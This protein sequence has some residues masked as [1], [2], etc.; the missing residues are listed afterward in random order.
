MSLNLVRS[1]AHNLLRRPGCITLR[2]NIPAMQVENARPNLTNYDHPDG[3]VDW[4]DRLDLPWY[5]RIDRD[6]TG[7]DGA[8]GPGLRS[9]PP[10]E[11]NLKPYR[12]S[13]A[14]RAYA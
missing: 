3:P 11:P 4:S 14:P 5:D 2:R 13:I 9:A 10:G 6:G 7:T 8:M 1:L 12:A